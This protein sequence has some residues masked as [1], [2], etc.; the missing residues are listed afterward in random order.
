MSLNIFKTRICLYL[1]ILFIIL[2]VFTTC[3]NSFVDPYAGTGLKQTPIPPLNT[4]DFHI[5]IIPDSLYI[6]QSGGGLFILFLESSS[7][8]AAN[9]TITALAAPSLNCKLTNDK[10]SITQRISELTIRPNS[11]IKTGNYNIHVDL[12]HNGS[13]QTIL[14]PVNVLSSF[15]GGKHDDLFL[16]FIH[17]IQNI[18]PALN[19]SENDNWFGYNK[20][21]GWV[22]VGYSNL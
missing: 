4:G 5:K 11:D 22:G 10:L 16:E 1:G 21:P 14:I 20:K 12:S 6:C 7:D 19:M 18:H 2:S 15:Y 8:F 3:N 17:W 9:V 13:P